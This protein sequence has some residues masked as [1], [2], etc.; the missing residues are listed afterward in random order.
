MVNHARTLLINR[1]RDGSAPD[2]LGEEFIEPT[3]VRRQLPSH[4]VRLHRLLFGR[5][6][7]RLFLNYRARQLMVILHCTELSEF[8]TRQDPRITYLPFLSTS[9]FDAAFQATAVQ[10]EGAECQ[11]YVTGEFVADEGRGLAQQSYRLQVLEGNVLQV[12]RQRPATQLTEIAYSLAGGLSLPISLPGSGLSVRFN[13]PAV[14]TVWRINI[15]GKP[16]GDIGQL[17]AKIETSLGDEGVLQVF[18][19]PYTEPVAT[20]KRVW[21]EH[22]SFLYRI[23]ALLLAAIE[24]MDAAPQEQ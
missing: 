1:G 22:S 3:F 5:E 13:T 18:P 6:P 9:L 12:T 23:S 16:A 15:A 20:F 21:D 19:P 17:L 11:L 8:V 10:H 24:Q 7:D 14:G 4:L 2:F